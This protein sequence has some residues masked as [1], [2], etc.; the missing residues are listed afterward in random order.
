[1]FL[2]IPDQET[3][4]SQMD[5]DSSSDDRHNLFKFLHR[6]EKLVKSSGLEEYEK[7]FNINSRSKSKTVYNHNNE[8]LYCA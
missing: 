3:G 4:E 2:N 6:L 1:M 5:I 8:D 7:H